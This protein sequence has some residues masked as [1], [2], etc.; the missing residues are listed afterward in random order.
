MATNGSIGRLRIFQSENRRTSLWY[1][2]TTY[3]LLVMT[4]AVAT[5]T[6]GTAGRTALA[7]LA[8][9]LWVRG[10]MLYHDHQHGAIFFG[11][12]LTR[13]I[14]VLFGYLVL[15]PPRYWRFS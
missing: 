6:S 12:K 3:S 10:F 14:F 11:S 13:W 7:L 9:A 1:V 5:V 4:V 8:S 2:V 15:A